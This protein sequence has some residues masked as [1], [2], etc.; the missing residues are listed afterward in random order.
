[1]VLLFF[2]CFFLVL[3]SFPGKGMVYGNRCERP[4]IELCSFSY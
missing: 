3:P 1:M 2:V 4:V